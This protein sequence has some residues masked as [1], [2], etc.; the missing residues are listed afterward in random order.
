MPWASFTGLQGWHTG[1][2]ISI[3]LALWKKNVFRARPTWVS[4][5]PCSWDFKTQL[6]YV[7]RE[8]TDHL[9]QLP[10]LCVHTHTY[11][12][13][14][15]T[16]ICMCVCIWTC[17]YMCNCLNIIV[18]TSCQV[19]FQSHYKCYFSLYN[20]TKGRHHYYHPI[21]MENW[22]ARKNWG[23]LEGCIASKPRSQDPNMQCGSDLVLLTTAFCCHRV[24]A[25]DTQPSWYSANEGNCNNISNYLLTTHWRQFHNALS[26]Y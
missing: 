23:T 21:Q 22:N 6:P 15:H 20:N 24:V 1:F 13:M 18:I 4:S 19:L 7:L 5:L 9:S 10:S 25:P 2:I 14:T 17:V 26:I 12:Y 8:H 16:C 11:M 3:Q